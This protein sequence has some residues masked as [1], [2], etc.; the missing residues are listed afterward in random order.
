M[1]YTFKFII[2]ITYRV[3][4]LS[5]PKLNLLII[6]GAIVLYIDVYFFVIP[7]TNQTVVTV[8]CNVTN[9][10][11]DLTNMYCC[12]GSNSFLFIDYSLVECSW[13]LSL[14]WYHPCKDVSSL[15]HIQ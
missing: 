12:T 9:N 13:I 8:F 4:H 6:L 14:L 7:T 2:L 15:Y 5:N 11:N 3:V 1:I 10:I